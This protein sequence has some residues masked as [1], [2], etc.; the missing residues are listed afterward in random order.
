M[1]DVF[2]YINMYIL[3]YQIDESFKMN[4]MDQLGV[5]QAHLSCK[6][7][8]TLT[9]FGACIKLILFFRACLNH[10]FDNF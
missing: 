10:Y 5:I 4:S 2:V 8:Q 6:A 3:N 9:I 1:A 7:Y